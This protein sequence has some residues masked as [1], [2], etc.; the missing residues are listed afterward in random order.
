MPYTLDDDEIAVIIRPAS[1]KDI[2][3]WNGNVT[4]GIVVGDDFALP[5]HVL[6]DLVH[7]ASMFTSAIDVMNYDDYVYDTVMD[8]RQQVLMNE[9]EN[10]EIKD[11]NTG[12]VINFNEFTK[13]K[14]NA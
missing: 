6:R 4:T 5:Q 12:E 13:T 8:H 10:Q 3:E 14:G 2:E 11:E 9:I 1:S 7:V